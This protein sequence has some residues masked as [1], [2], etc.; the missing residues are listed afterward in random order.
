[1]NTGKAILSLTLVLIIS[2]E[3][4]ISAQIDNREALLYLDFE[5]NPGVDLRHGTKVREGRFGRALEF[6]TAMQYAEVE[7][8]K[9]LDGVEAMSV[10]GWFFPWRTGEQAIVS[11]GTRRACGVAV[12]L[13]CA[14]S[15]PR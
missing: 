4:K 3:R 13:P 2:D 7:F 14:D 6:T 10:G 15:R 1:M 12:R 8:S 11:R 9:K 5:R